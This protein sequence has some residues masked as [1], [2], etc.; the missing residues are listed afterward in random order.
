[1]W[2]TALSYGKELSRSLLFAQFSSWLIFQLFLCL[3]WWC[4]YGLIWQMYKTILLLL[5]LYTEKRKLK[6]CCFKQIIC[7]RLIFETQSSLYYLKRDTLTFDREIP[8]YHRHLQWEAFKH[9]P[10]RWDW[11][12]HARTSSFNEMNL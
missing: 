9:H 3:F 7:S 12:V 6:S 5:L 1:M 11:S 2:N 8:I 4:N 10:E